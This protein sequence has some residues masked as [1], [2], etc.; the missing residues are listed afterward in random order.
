LTALVELTVG[1]GFRERALE[2]GGVFVIE[3]LFE[4]L[5]DGLPGRPPRGLERLDGDEDAI[6]DRL[7]R[8]RFGGRCHRDRRRGD[9]WRES[10][11]SALEKII[12]FDYEAKGERANRRSSSESDCD[13][14]YS[15]LFYKSRA[16]RLAPF[17]VRRRRR[18]VYAS[19]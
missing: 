10:G 2:R 12:R 9:K 15:C 19:M 3:A 4:K 6:E 17:R 11:A 14:V 8:L 7:G 16:R 1:D 13:Y 5:C 18:L